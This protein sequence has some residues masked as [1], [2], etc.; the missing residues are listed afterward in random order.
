MSTLNKMIKVN[1][2]IIKAELSSSS[3]NELDFF[4]FPSYF[5]RSRYLHV[6]LY[7]SVFVSVACM[8]NHLFGKA[9]VRDLLTLPVLDLDHCLST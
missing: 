4:E 8:K 3:V 6:G 1:S 5:Y 7:Y 9:V 2:T